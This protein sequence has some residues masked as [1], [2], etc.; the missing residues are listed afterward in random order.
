MWSRPHPQADR[1]R[2]KARV[3]AIAA[4]L[5]RSPSMVSREI[6]RN[7][8]PGNGWHRPMPLRPRGRPPDEPQG[9]EDRTEP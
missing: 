4:E 5:G 6:R 7:R 9:R 3:R 2:E 1:L 8:H